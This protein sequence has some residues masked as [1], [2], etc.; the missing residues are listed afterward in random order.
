[1]MEKVR[2][3]SLKS[4]ITQRIIFT[5]YSYRIKDIPQVTDDILTCFKWQ[6]TDEG[7]TNCKRQWKCLTYTQP[8]STISISQKNF[9]F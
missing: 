7:G 9:L 2:T 1:M 6:Y 4:E 8:G 5:N 3:I